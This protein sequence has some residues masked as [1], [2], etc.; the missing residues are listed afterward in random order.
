MEGQTVEFNT[1]V[2]IDDDEIIDYVK[3]NYAPE[4]IFDRRDLED[5]ATGEGHVIEE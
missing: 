1:D 4:D 5:W 3:S 2:K